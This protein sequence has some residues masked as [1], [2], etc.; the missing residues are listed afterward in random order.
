MIDLF[1]YIFMTA[2]NIVRRSKFILID[3]NLQESINKT[4]DLYE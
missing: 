2:E 1:G 3:K 4:I